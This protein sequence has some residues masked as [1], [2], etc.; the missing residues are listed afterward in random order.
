MRS[1]AA[2]LVA[3]A[4]APACRASPA[5]IEEKRVRQAA[6]AGQFYPADPAVLAAEVRSLMSKAPRTRGAS[7]MT[8]RPRP[9][10]GPAVLRRDRRR[11]VLRR[12]D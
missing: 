6:A 10:R 3:A 9:S 2:V 4:L 5:A 1:L 7:G 11:S 8:H 12:S